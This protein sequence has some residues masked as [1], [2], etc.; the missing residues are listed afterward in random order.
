[1]RK[2]NRFTAYLEPEVAR[3]IKELAKRNQ[4]SESQVIDLLLKKALGI[5]APVINN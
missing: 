1:M 4:R 5:A 2:E 3:R